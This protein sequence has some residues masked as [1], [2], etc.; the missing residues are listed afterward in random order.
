MTEALPRQIRIN[1]EV[2][3]R[4]TDDTCRRIIGRRDQGAAPSDSVL[5]SKCRF[6]RQM[7]RVVT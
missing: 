5:M 1:V 3:L 7:T 2:S 6:E 4:A